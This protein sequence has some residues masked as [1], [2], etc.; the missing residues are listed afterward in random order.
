MNNSDT[1]T[2]V[3]EWLGG[4]TTLGL[5]VLGIWQA[6]ISLS[7]ESIHDIPTG[8]EAIRSGETTDKF[9]KHLDKHLPWR[10]H[11]IATANVGRYVLTRGA[12]DQ[13]RLGRDEWLFSVEELQFSPYSQAHM[14]QRLDLASHLARQLASHQVNLLVLL[15]PDKARVHAEQLSNGRYP[16]W[17]TDR[18]TQALMGLQS[19]HIP[20]VNLLETFERSKQAKPLYYRTDTHWNQD[21]ALL[22]S[23]AVAAQMRSAFAAPSWAQTRFVSESPPQPK[24]RVG[25]LLTM[26]SMAHVP[27]WLRPNPDMEPKAVTRK[28]E[29]SSALGLFGDV[30]MPVVLTG[31]SYSMRANFHGYLQAALETE[32]LNVA[33]DGGGFLQSIQAYLSDDAFKSSPPKL[34]VWEIPERMFGQPLTEQELAL[35]ATLT[36]AR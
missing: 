35:S 24:E 19:R 1:D 28:Q 15:V 18:Y 4:L 25:D 7:H 13:V 32:V 14:T 12:G 33:K 27:N 30:N 16:A 31:T 20:V 11:L 2:T 6:T 21:G 8:L 10:E 36:S 3:E 34:L 22:A 9:S 26:M 17:N 29:E 23:Q 5:L